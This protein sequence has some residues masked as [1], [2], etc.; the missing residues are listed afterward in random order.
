MDQVAGGR[1]NVFQQDGAPAH[2]SKR[3]QD[4]CRVNLPEFWWKELWL[5]SSPDCNPL[6]YFVWGVSELHVNKTP[7]NTSA[8][9]MEKITEVMGNLD[10]D[11]MAKACR[12][13]RS[14]I[15]AV[16]VTLSNKTIPSMF[17]YH[18]VF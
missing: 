15:E 8:A 1:P 14:R 18:L 11:T 9:L 7:H 6:D 13:F 2:N 16:V 5:P 10:K 17:I 4:W 3:T 12:R